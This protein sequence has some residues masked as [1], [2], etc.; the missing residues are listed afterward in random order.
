MA[1]TRINNQA[2]PTG[3]VLQVKSTNF[4]NALTYGSS[5]STGVAT[6]VTNG[7]S[8]IPS[9]IYV[10][11]TATKANSKFLIQF[12]GNA[13]SSNDTLYG[14]WII[15]WG[16][17][18]DPAGGTSWTQIGHGTNTTNANN[19]KFFSSRADASGG[20]ND[21]WHAM[22][23]AGSYLYS[24]TVS[25][26]TTLRFAIEYFHYDNA[27]HETLRINNRS[28]GL[29]GNEVYTGGMATTLSVTEIAG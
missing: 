11:I 27:S 18:V 6:N 22:Q 9:Q 16:F 28:A 7:F 14:D 3:T 29:A 26:G 25:A 19:V 12:D 10:N 8:V 4:N 23:L 17:V 1:L 13:S 2:L 20:G 15:G 21:A 5:D 24:S